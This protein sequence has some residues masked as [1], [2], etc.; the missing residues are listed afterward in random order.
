MKRENIN[1]GDA[2]QPRGGYS[3]AVRLEDFQ[4]LLFVSGQVPLSAEDVLPEGFEAQARQVWSNIDAQLRAAGM[5]KADIVKVTVL[6]A[7][8]QHAMANRAAR[9]EYLGALAPAMTVAIAGIFDAGWLL[10]IDV[11]AAQ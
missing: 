5:S 11:I 7:D 3:Q 1:A 9:Q 6:L 10:E 2:P 8:R 4:R